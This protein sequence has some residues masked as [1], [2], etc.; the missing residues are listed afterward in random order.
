MAT[1]AEEAALLCSLRDASSNNTSPV[2]REDDTIV[3]TIV[4]THIENR[5]A[6]PS[7]SP[8]DDRQLQTSTPAL[9]PLE[10]SSSVGVSIDTTEAPKKA[11]KMRPKDPRKVRFVLFFLSYAFVCSIYCLGDLATSNELSLPLCDYFCKPHVLTFV[12]ITSPSFS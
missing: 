11:Y 6:I 7:S 5:T 12:A 2:E 4:K 3:D 9:P 8:N 1:S 10:G